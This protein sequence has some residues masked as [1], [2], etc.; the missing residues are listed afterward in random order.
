MKGNLNL[1]LKD[2][3]TQIDLSNEEEF[4]TGYNILPACYY[5]AIR[6]F[7]QAN[8]PLRFA[9]ID[10]QHRSFGL[11]LQLLNRTTSDESV[12]MHWNE[13]RTGQKDFKNTNIDS[14][15]QVRFIQMSPISG[16]SMQKADVVSSLI[17]ES[18]Q[19][20]ITNK[21]LMGDENIDQM[22]NI[23]TN[24][25]DEKI[26]TETTVIGEVRN[27]TETQTT[28]GMKPILQRLQHWRKEICRRVIQND[29]RSTQ[30]EMQSK[31]LA[32]AELFDNNSIFDSKSLKYLFSNVYGS[33]KIRYSEGNLSRSDAALFVFVCT[34]RLD[35]IFCEKIKKI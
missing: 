24:L 30:N 7:I 9:M 22:L 20:Q 12:E 18:L 23:L 8:T 10:G 34:A 19:V 33:A 2:G 17:D 21:K 32:V 35:S 26:P 25:D 3:T 13:Q 4:I 15:M 28:K 16:K 29:Y 5:Q 27:L 31:M 11:Y 14:S 6:K 1:E